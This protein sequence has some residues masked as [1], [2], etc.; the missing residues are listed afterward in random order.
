MLGRL[1]AALMTFYEHSYL[2]A[3]V[4][5]SAPSRPQPPPELQGPPLQL[6]AHRSSTG[7]LARRGSRK[8]P[9][10]SLRARRIGTVRFCP[11]G[12]RPPS[13]APPTPCL[14][15]AQRELPA[16]LSVCPHHALTTLLPVLLR[17]PLR[18]Y[19]W[20]SGATGRR[21]LPW[22]EPAPM[23]R[24]LNGE[25]H[26]LRLSLSPLLLDGWAGPRVGRQ[27]TS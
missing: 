1:F 10:G 8:R 20:V 9:R 6:T 27:A 15:A 11:F 7:A 14:K 26:R 3:L 22:W 21:A 16:L 2:Q 25:R 23:H 4:P 19:G 13:G 17:P 5:A 18:E 12:E 24:R